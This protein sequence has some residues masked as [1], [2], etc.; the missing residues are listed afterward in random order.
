MASAVAPADALAALRVAPASEEPDVPRGTSLEE[1]ELGTCC[2]VRTAAARAASSLS[3]ES[4][5]SLLDTP[6]EPRFDELTELVCTLCG[7]DAAFVSLVDAVGKRIFFKSAF[8]GP[9]AQGRLG[10]GD[11]PLFADVPCF[12]EHT[13]TTCAPLTVLNAATDE[14]WR[15]C[16]VVARAGVSFYAGAPLEVAPGHAVGSLCVVSFTPR[17]E[18]TPAQARSLKVLSNQVVAQMQLGLAVGHLARANK[19]LEDAAAERERKDAA[20]RAL[21]EGTAA[22]KRE[23][24]AAVSH[25]LRT[26]LTGVAGA[27][28]LLSACVSEGSEAAELVELMQTGAARMCA[29]LDDILDFGAIG[30]GALRLQIAPFRVRE[31]MVAPVRKMLEC[32]AQAARI[33]PGVGGDVNLQQRGALF[34]HKLS[35][36]H[37]N[38][39]IDPDVP[40]VLRGDVAR[41]CQVGLNLM[42]NVRT[43]AVVAVA[44]MPCPARAHSF[45]H[46]L[47]PRHAHTT[48]AQ[49]IKFTPEGGSVSLRVFMRGESL[50]L[51]VTD[52]GIGLSA[53]SLAAVFQPFIQADTDTRER[54]GGTGLGLAI[55][56]RIAATMGGE[57][58]A[59]SEGLGHGAVFT[60]AAPVGTADE[61]DVRDPNRWIA[62]PEALAGAPAEAPAQPA[63]PAAAAAGSPA[64]AEAVSSSS[65]VPLLRVLA[66][67]DDSLCRTVLRATLRRMGASAV[68][69]EDGA[70]AVAAFAAAR[71]AFDYVLLDFHMPQLSGPEAT[72]AI[73]R[74]ATEL[75]VRPPQVYVVTGAT[76]PEAASAAVAAGATGFLAK[77][78]H[79]AS[80]Q[81]LLSQARGDVVAVDGP[82]TPNVSAPEAPS[83]WSIDSAVSEASSSGGGVRTA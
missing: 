70:A 66:A 25:E 64:P 14:A 45:T 71:G 48:V 44:A 27:A 4:V 31:Q 33:Q 69:V 58:T 72:V 26:P 47:S 53:K 61:A 36:L 54:F 82:P 79:V 77:P 83:R 42:T 3:A 68:V 34:A 16:I 6:A 46:A 21:K 80:I 24:M 40:P 43:N 19:Q 57:L 51:C 59:A 67:D 29:L 75:E 23:F 9:A 8:L 2:L 52:T 50:G 78:L 7:G 15:D 60:F 5:L 18:W 13:A 22:S 55:C 74:L 32:A 49:A 39:D 20:Y 76:E 11:L 63:A 12:C 62:P 35:V 37:V 81:V 1:E 10:P 38:Y 30:Q 56:K 73:L 28:A 41:L 17:A 65:S